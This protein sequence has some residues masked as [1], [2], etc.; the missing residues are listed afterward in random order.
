MVRNRNN[1]GH[2]QKESPNQYKIEGNIAKIYFND[3]SYTIIDLDDLE[4]VIKYKWYKGCARKETNS[5]KEYFRI[6]THINK[7]VVRLHRFILNVE[8]GQIVDHINQNTFDNRKA[9]LRIVNNSINSRNRKAKKNSSSKYKGVYFR[10]DRN[11]WVAQIRINK[12]VKHLGIFETEIE[13][14][15]AYDK[16]L[17]LYLNHS[18]GANFL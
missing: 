9:N 2:F 12:K 18:I 8:K 5:R 4:R 1:K 14:A 6:E 13:A 3:Y 10:Y 15:K 17:K 7:K 11:K 16:A